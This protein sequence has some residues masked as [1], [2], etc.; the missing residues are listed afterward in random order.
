VARARRAGARR[1]ARRGRVRAAAR[2][3]AELID[4]YGITTEQ[5]GDGSTDLEW[6]RS[7]GGN[8]HWYAAGDRL[9][10]GIK[11]YA[12]CEHNN[13]VLWIESVGAIVA[14]D[15]LGRLRNGP[16]A[17]RVV[18]RGV[19]REQVVERLRP[20]LA[21]RVEVVLPAHGA[22]TDRAALERALS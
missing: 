19:T 22:P 7:G 21:L 10:I 2:H 9:P 15:S 4:K 13:L 17:E 6:L 11:A 16:R 14:G 18:A 20:L 8:A 3:R 5:A 1:A 12:G